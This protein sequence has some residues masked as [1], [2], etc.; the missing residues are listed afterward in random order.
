M[1]IV[2]GQHF[3]VRDHLRRHLLVE[4]FADEQLDDGF[5]HE[6]CDLWIGVVAEALGALGEERKGAQALYEAARSTTGWG[7]LARGFLEPGSPMPPARRRGSA[8]FQAFVRYAGALWQLEPAA[9][10]DDMQLLVQGG[11]FVD[12]AP[13]RLF[14]ADRALEL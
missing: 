12:S 10:L 14:M 1:F 8:L 2:V 3:L 7:Y 13:L 11:S 6:L 5:V 4:L 9:G